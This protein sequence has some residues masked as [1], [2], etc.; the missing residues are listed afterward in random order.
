MHS[1]N[2]EAQMKHVKRFR[3]YRPTLNDQFDKPKSSSRKPSDR[4]QTRKPDFESAF[5]RLHKKEKE[6]RKLF[7]FQ[8]PNAPEKIWYEL[9]FRSMVPRLVNRCRETVGMSCFQPTMKIMLWWSHVV[10][11]VLWIN[12]AKWTESFAYCISISRLNA[13]KNTHGVYIIY[14]TKPSLSQ[15]LRLEKTHLPDYQRK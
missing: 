1:M 8:D 2:P 12:K 10:V 14:T 3:R 11:S 7:T 5:D 15:K 4:N 9:F 6:S 13:L